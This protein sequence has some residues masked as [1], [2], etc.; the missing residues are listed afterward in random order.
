MAQVDCQHRLGYLADTP[1]EFAFMSFIGLSVEE[2]ME[3]FRTINGKA[4]GLSSS[5]LDYTESKLLED[6]LPQVKPELYIALQLNSD[7]RSPWY[8]KLDLGGQNTV[9]TKRIASLRTMQKAAKRFLREAGDFVPNSPDEVVAIVIDFWIALTIVL[10]TAWTNPRDHLVNKGVGVYC[11][12]SIAGELVKEA[13]ATRQKCNV[14]YFIS[15]LSDF[16]DRIDWSNRGSLMGFGGAKGADAALELVRT[17]R[18]Q[19]Q[20]IARIYG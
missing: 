19:T 4:K 13:S 12:M 5:L 2:E 15:K 8:Q 6:S 17:I 11:L 20:P 1:I 7:Q 10:Q 18:R 16:I 9:G 14:D 3:V